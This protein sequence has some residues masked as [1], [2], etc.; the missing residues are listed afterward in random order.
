MRR[1]FR[2]R[3][4]IWTALLAGIALTGFIAIAWWQIRETRLDVI[5]RE[6]ANQLEREISR[7]WP[8]EHWPRHE[9]NMAHDFG[10]HTNQQ[11]LLLVQDKG[12]IIYRS[13]HW[14]NELVPD[15][16][17]WLQSPPLAADNSNRF[18][19][20][21]LPLDDNSQ[22]RIDESRP[23]D[24]RVRSS[25]FTNK[26]KP[27]KTH[28]ASDL[29]PIRF[30]LNLISLPAAGRNWRI[31]LA[32][33]LAGEQLAIG[34]DLA[35]LETDMTELHNASVIAASIALGFIALG[36]WLLSSR[37]LSP[38]KSL[39]TAMENISA[40][41]LDQ[42]LSCDNSDH[43]FL[44]LIQVFNSMLERLERSFQQASRFSADAAHELK[45]PLAILQGQI[46]RAL[47]QSEAGSPA[48]TYLTKI[49]DEV[50]RLSAISRKLLL[51]SLADAGRLRLYLSPFDLSIALVD[52]LEDAQ[53]LAPELEVND[54][55]AQGLK[56]NVD[57]ELF[58]HVLHNLLSN[59]IKYN[60][61]KG[62]IHIDAFTSPEGIEVNISNASEGIPM[63]DR[64]RIFERFYRADPDHTRQIEGM[65]L[66]LSLSRE[67]VRAHGGDL[68]LL[69]S[70]EGRVVFRVHLPR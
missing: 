45:T 67:I 51:L 23:P 2:L 49:L 14:P 13:R 3:I 22:S 6:I 58:R 52:L 40:K 47:T 20:K 66:G 54:S 8:A 42:R 41:G 39:T 27:E 37:A 36:A 57:A 62:W 15:A 59:A 44:L 4:A 25:T 46:E 24:N 55:I 69:D 31:G 35:V 33:D 5:D 9:Q 64:E 17:P 18:L 32:N 53:M 10:T 34:V 26:L 70:V 16:L 38:I 29:S 61:P 19:I 63:A 11:L 48:Q 56:I 68:K 60:L 28:A 65:G 50:Q 7:Q 21:P 1:S 12:A 30:G 43:E